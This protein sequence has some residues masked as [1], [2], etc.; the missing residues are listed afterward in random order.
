LAPANGD[1][2]AAIA[3]CGR[4]TGGFRPDAIDANC[5]QSGGLGIKLLMSKMGDIVNPGGRTNDT[6]IGICR[7]VSKIVLTCPLNIGGRVKSCGR[8]TVNC[9]SPD[10][11]GAAV[12]DGKLTKDRNVKKYVGG[13]DD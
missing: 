3:D 11:V 9:E 12:G 10:R 5:V 6:S 8:Y 2:A 4:T 13:R 7:P 1:E